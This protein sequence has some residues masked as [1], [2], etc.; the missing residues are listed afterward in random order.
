M[1]ARLNAMAA[2]LRRSERE[3]ERLKARNAVLRAELESARRAGKRQSAPFSKGPP[4]AKPRR[5]GRKPG[6]DYGTPARRLAPERFDEICD[7][8]LPDQCPD[9]AGELVEDGVLEQ[10]Q[11]EIPEPRPIHRRIDIHLGH[12]T[13]CGRK[14][15]G[16]HPY[17]TSEAVGAAAAQVGPRAT[18]AIAQLNKRCGLSFEKTQQV[19]ARLFGVTIS[20][21][22]VWHATWRASRAAEPTY[23]AIEKA[24]EASPV[25]TVDETSW[26][27]EAILRWLWVF[28]TRRLVF[29]KI[30]PGRGYEH[31]AAILGE[32]FSG[33]IVR[34]GWPPYLKFTEALHQACYAHLTRRCREM[35]SDADRGQARVPHALL[36]IL[37]RAL[38]LRDARDLGQLTRSELAQAIA[39]LNVRV[40][41][42]L[43]GNITHPPNVTL[44][45]HV[46]VQRDHLFT[47]LE[48]DGV[49]AT[50]YRA[51]QGVR[52]IVVTRKV[53]GGNRT[54]TGAHTQEI[55]CT[56]I[57]TATLQELDVQTILIDLLR[58]P[59]PL[60]APLELEPER[61]PPR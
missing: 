7:A 60:I 34:D 11:T 28:A 4:K 43:A 26:K 48:H 44:L 45:N 18:A 56:L 51:E 33:V 41:K 1:R 58:S 9:C 16:R 12:C 31:A 19:M 35:I 40:D 52:P 32:N 39:L 6:A 20:R 49:D 59:H 54:W 42:L 37:R 53:W 13:G 46:A 30:A 36:R 3:V 8:P 10:S 47:F 23:Q 14:V 55:L 5:P 29:Y 27:V 50:N 22:G 21:S 15:R 17:Q 57:A 24:I 2:R 38:R 25:V 61:A